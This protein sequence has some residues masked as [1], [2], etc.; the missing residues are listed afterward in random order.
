MQTAIVTD[1]NS[2]ISQSEAGRLGVFVLPMPVIIEKHAYYEGIDLMPDRF[3]HA[4]VQHQ[5][6]STSQPSPGDVTALWERVLTEYDELVYIPMSSGLS[7]SCA[8]AA[9]L[10]KDYA[11]RVFVVDNHR[12]SVTQKDSVLDALALCEAGACAREIQQELENSA[13]DSIIY[14]GVETLE[15]LRRGGRVTSKAAAISTILQIKPLLKI[16]GE[17]L[18]AYAKVRGT[19]GCKKRLLE[20][21]QEAVEKYSLKWDIDI[22]IASSYQDI[23]AAESWRKTTTDKFSQYHICSSPLTFSI[24]SHV[25][26]DAFGM[27]VSRRLARA[28]GEI[29]N[30]SSHSTNDS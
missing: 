16:E 24:G 20:A 14:I 2:G 27:A 4:L 8:T 22:G 6:V 1:S 15:Y 7:S 28:K 25:G 9:I 5:T 19:A 23:G 12:I 29:Q 26:P 3:F 30:E 17:R 18:D 21:M 11:G 13:F 10:A